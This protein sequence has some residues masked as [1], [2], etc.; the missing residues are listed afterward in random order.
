MTWNFSHVGTGPESVTNELSTLKAWISFSRTGFGKLQTKGQKPAICFANV[1]QLRMVGGKIFVVTLTIL[2][3]LISVSIK[4]KF[5]WNSNAHLLPYCLWMPLHCNCKV[6]V[7]TETTWCTSLKYYLALYRKFANP[8]SKT[9]VCNKTSCIGENIL[10]AVQ[11]SSH[12]ILRWRNWFNLSIS[13]ATCI[14]QQSSRKC[15]L[16]LSLGLK[17]LQCYVFYL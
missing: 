2:C 3:I 5:Y 8:C 6:A 7:A 1:L 4:I 13:T 10:W 11:Y 14:V 12:Y 15:G 16:S 9:A 17:F